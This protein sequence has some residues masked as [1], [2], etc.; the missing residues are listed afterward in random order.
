L[1]SSYVTDHQSVDHQGNRSSAALMVLN[2]S[3]PH[4]SRPDAP[5]HRGLYGLFWRF[6]GDACVVQPDVASLAHGGYYPG[7]PVLSISSSPSTV[8]RHDQSL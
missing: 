1:L 8:Q 2:A 6:A 3:D 5:G 4:G 7:P